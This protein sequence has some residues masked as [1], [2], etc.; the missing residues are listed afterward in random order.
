MKKLH[1]EQKAILPMLKVLKTR[2]TFE[3]NVI[4]VFEHNALRDINVQ[5]GE[6]IPEYELH[7]KDGNLTAKEIL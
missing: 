7:L 2:D 1:P 3:G 4:I 6:N 5:S